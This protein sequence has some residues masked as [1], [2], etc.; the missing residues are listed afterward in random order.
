MQ[1]P[2]LKEDTLREIGLHLK[3]YPVRPDKAQTDRGKEGSRTPNILQMRSQCHLTASGVF[4]LQPHR[5]EIEALME[6]IGTLDYN[7]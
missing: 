7:F 1:F 3:Y 4:P 6:M 2:A 5:T